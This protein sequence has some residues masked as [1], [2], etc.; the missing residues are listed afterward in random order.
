V[1]QH[2]CRKWKFSEWLTEGVLRH[3]TPLTA[4]GFSFPGA[5]IFVAHFVSM[6]DLTGEIIA[7]LLPTELLARLGLDTEALT[8]A[9]EKYFALSPAGLP[10]K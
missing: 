1:G 4:A 2:L 5:M 6:S 9:K 10:P 3:H 7:S 8:A